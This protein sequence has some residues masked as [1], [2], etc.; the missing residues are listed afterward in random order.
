MAERGIRLVYGGGSVGIMGV[1]ANAAHEAGGS[2]KGIIP[3]SL[4]AREVTGSF[5]NADEME[6]VDTMHERKARMAELSDAFIALPGGF[7]TLDE[8]FEAVTWTQ[9]GI[10]DKPV[11]LLDVGGFYQPLLQQVQRAVEDGFV[12]PA[13][14][15][16][17]V[18]HSEGPGLLDRLAEHLLPDSVLDWSKG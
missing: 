14:A 2:V 7:G 8:T 17:F 15:N 12:K 1:V 6:L 16:I 9:L 18:V 13:H 10:H 11:G 4:S 5:V 3:R